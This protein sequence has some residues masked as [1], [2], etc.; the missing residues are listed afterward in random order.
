VRWTALLLLL[1]NLGVAG[2]LLLIDRAPKAQADL[3]VLELNADKVKS[4]KLSAGV[5]PAVGAG[6]CLQWG[7]FT[8]AELDRAL[9]QIA[10]LKPAKSAARDLDESPVW[11]VHVP[12]FKTRE[13]AERRLREIE[14]AGTKEARLI[15][16]GERWRN[17]ISLGI[18]KSEEAAN[19][20]LARMKELK[21]RNVAVVR[22]TDLIKLAVIVVADPAPALVTRVMELKAGFEGTDVK[23]GACPAGFS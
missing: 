11:W 19:A 15:A 17:A 23:A 2:Y 3:R 1:A 22:R 5:P 10:R 12:P 21:V 16:E 18:F 6:A 7:N 20:Y 8:S 14:D 13:E 4:L 9:E